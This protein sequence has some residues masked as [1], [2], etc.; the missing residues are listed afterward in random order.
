[1]KSYAND[2]EATEGLRTLYSQLNAII[3]LTNI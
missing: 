3:F 1:M 2:V